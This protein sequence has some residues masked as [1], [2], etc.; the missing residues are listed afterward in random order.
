LN[1]LADYPYTVRAVQCDVRASDEDVYQ[2]VRRA[3][4]PLTQ[5]WARLA[6]AKTIAVKANQ[7]RLPENVVY[8]QG[9]RQQ[10]VSDQVAR[11][12]LRLLRERTR[13]ELIA[14]DYGVEGIF[15]NRDD[16]VTTQL[17]DMYREFGLRLELNRDLPV[18]WADVPGGGWMFDRYP[19]P[20]L[21][22][23]ADEI[24]SIQKM[25][26]HAFMGVTLCTKNLFGLVP[27]P[28]GGRP[29]IYYHHLVRMPY[30]LAD[31]A[32]ILDPALNIIDG[33]VAQAGMEWGA[34]EHPRVCNTILAGDHVIATDA[35]GTCLMG[36]DPHDDWPA[37]PFHR[38]RNAVLI[39]AQGGFGTVDLDQIDFSTEVPVP[40]DSFF[41]HQLDPHEMVSSWRRT[42]AEQ[43]LFFRDRRAWFENRY[44]GQYILLQRGEVRWAGPEWNLFDS[45]R[46]L[47]GMYPEEGMWMKFVDP[48][49]AEGEHFE[50]Y[51]QTL[52][53][54]AAIAEKV[55]EE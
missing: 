51:E 38:D 9:H 2:A 34:G 46:K 33:I 8:H 28:P 47:A 35:C 41:T 12:V 50:V 52:M 5:A 11:A 19:L 10:L 21:A 25:K 30:M 40:V 27:L 16:G 1:H 39:G 44:A 3:T 23:E 36:H 24:V 43:A 22:V 32:K 15:N 17:L 45:R 14:V 7:D 42:T 26:S 4:E 37:P 29:R 49:E 13:A 18:V 54:V 53:E 6:R 20:K 48:A 55:H 31:I